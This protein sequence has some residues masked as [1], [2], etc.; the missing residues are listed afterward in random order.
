MRQY[1]LWLLL[2]PA[3]LFHFIP[4]QAQEVAQTRFGFLDAPDKLFNS[5]NDKSRKFSERFTAQAEKYLAKLQKREKKLRNRLASKDSALAKKLF[6]D[7]DGQYAALRA[8]LND[9]AAGIRQGGDVYVGYLDSMKTALNFLQQQ[10]LF[11]DGE[12]VEGVLKEYK[13]LQQKLNSTDDIKKY[14]QQRQQYLKQQLQNMPVAKEFRKFQQDVYYYKAQI[15]EYREALEDPSKLEAKLLQAARKIPAFRNFFNRHSMLAGIFRLPADDDPLNNLVAGLQTRAS[16]QQHLEQR[17]GNSAD[18]RNALQQGMQSARSELDNLKAKLQQPGGSDNDIPG[19]KPNSQKTKKFWDRIELGT[20]I[21]ST[22]GSSFF[23]VTSDIALSAGYKLNDKS[24]VGL[25]ASYKIGWGRDVRHIKITHE[26]VGLRSFLDWKIKGGLYASGGF[27]YNYQ[28]P[29]VPDQLFYEADNWQ[30]S[31]LIGLSKIVSVR[32]KFF[33]KTKLQL[34]WDFLSYE[35]VP[36]TQPV[37]FRVG[38]AF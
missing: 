35:Q 25:G 31:G 18:I 11:K 12:K 24:I 23:P 1:R 36:R 19:F 9:S 37:K 33:K 4:S 28:Q 16:V 7:I 30:Q 15:N 22:K 6:G 8:G 29:F 17:F 27:E 10:N 38:Y 32:S 34:L 5:I 21:Q 2:L 20:N 14:V 26:G 3:L 13:L